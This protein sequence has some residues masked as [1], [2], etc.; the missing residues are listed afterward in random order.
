MTVV[1][2][3]KKP[4]RR[5]R[6]NAK[7]ESTVENLAPQNQPANDPNMRY[8]KTGA[9]IPKAPIG[10]H[11]AMGIAVALPFVGVITAIVL[12]WQYGWMGW[13]YL[14]MLIAG[15]ILTGMGITIGFHRLMAHRSFETH[16]VIRAFWMCLGA[17]SVE[18]APLT[19]CAIHRKHHGKSDQHGDPHSP[20]LHGE[21]FWGS[22]RGLWY[23]QVGWLF[24]GYWSSP[25]LEKYV[26]DLLKDRLLTFCNKYYLLFVFASLS[27]PALL[28]AGWVYF[29]QPGGSVWFGALLGLI[30]GGLVRICVTHHVT[31]SINSL[32]HVFGSRPY[33]SGD[34]STNNLI[35]GLWGFGEGWHNNHHAFPTSARHGLQWWQFDSSWLVIRSMQ[36]LGLAW[37]VKLPTKEAMRA[38]ERK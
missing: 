26:P 14:A 2:P 22:L 37:N 12:M 25:E 38:K 35:C 36:L 28:G 13:P 21:G 24:A 7:F 29:F 16:R 18:G 3:T 20:H 11:I 9:P 4:K 32:C 5:K 27:I 17:L 30:W 34:L 6:K 8:T 1:T 19:W 23:S 31:W 33:E 10:Q 15:W